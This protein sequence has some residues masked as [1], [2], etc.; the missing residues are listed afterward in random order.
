M[1]AVPSIQALPMWFLRLHTSTENVITFTAGSAPEGQ[2]ADMFG[3]LSMEPPSAPQSQSGLDALMGL[4]TSTPGPPA[5]PPAAADLF[6]G[7]SIGGESICLPACHPC[8][9]P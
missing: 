1:V 8:T 2:A 9:C 6:G 3:G 4:G 7:L 5:Q